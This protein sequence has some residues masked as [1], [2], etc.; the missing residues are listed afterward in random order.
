MAQ[1]IKV[2]ECAEIISKKLGIPYGDLIDVLCEISTTDVVELVPCKE[3]RYCSNNPSLD[4]YRCAR[5]MSIVS[6]DHFCGL[7]DKKKGTHEN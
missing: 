1:Y 5:F 7:G 3:C 2:T 4:I 6:S